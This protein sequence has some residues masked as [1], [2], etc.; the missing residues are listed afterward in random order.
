[1]NNK[2]TQANNKHIVVIHKNILK[3]KD[4]QLINSLGVAEYIDDERPVVIVLEALE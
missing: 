2:L 1:M 4:N 3:L